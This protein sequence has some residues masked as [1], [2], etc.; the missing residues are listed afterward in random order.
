MYIYKFTFLQIFC[1]F[2]FFQNKKDEIKVG[3]NLFTGN[4]K[5]DSQTDRRKFVEPFE[6][7]RRIWRDQMNKD[8]LSEVVVR[9]RQYNFTC[10]IYHGVGTQE[11]HIP[12]PLFFTPL[13]VSPSTKRRGLSERQSHR[14]PWI[15][16]LVRG[17]D[18]PGFCNPMTAVLMSASSKTGENM[19]MAP[20]A[21]FSPKKYRVWTSRPSPR[22]ILPCF[23]L[24]SCR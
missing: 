19:E 12:F 24:V 9:W 16:F 20:I 1:S 23:F 21:G 22:R 11:I 3:W 15:C 14:I 4:T 13:V 8:I 18:L 17:K 10:I 5:W 2:K 6:S 7:L